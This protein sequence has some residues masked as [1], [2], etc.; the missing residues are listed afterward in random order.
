MNR[1]LNHSADTGK[2]K[3]GEGQRGLAQLVCGGE[4][5]TSSGFIFAH[6]ERE[7]RRGNRGGNAALKKNGEHLRK[8][9]EDLKPE[10]RKRTRLEPLGGEKNVARPRR[11]PGRK[12]K[13][14]AVIHREREKTDS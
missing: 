4:S 7:K 10:E 9:L 6:K 2:S 14:S 1:K 11:D 13:G 8:S 5:G 3:T 12:K